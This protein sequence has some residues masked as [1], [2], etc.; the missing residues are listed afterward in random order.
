MQNAGTLVTEEHLVDDSEH[1]GWLVL[2][3]CRANRV[4][5]ERRDDGRLD[6]LAF[7]V[8]ECDDPVVGR[9]LEH[10]V[11]VAADLVAGAGGR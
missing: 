8:A 9:D 2:D 3:R 6:A 7:D 1:A 11:E 10:V 5:H 4:A